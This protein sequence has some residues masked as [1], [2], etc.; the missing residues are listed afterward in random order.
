MTRL[1]GHFRLHRGGF[2]LDTAFDS[3]GPGVTALCGPSGAGKTS[4][5]R[6]L[7]GLETPEAGSLTVGGEVW[8]DAERGVS[9][10]PQRRSIGY[11]T[12]E[13]SLFAHLTVED[14]L[15]YGFKRLAES[16]RKASLDDVVDGL[17]LK[18]LLSRRVTN[19]SGG[20]RQ[21]VAIGR[22]LLRSPQVLLLDE[23]VSALDVA[24]RADVLR[25]LRQVLERFAVRSIYVSHDLRE[26]ARLAN[27]MLWMERGKV[28]AQGNARDVLTDVHL[29]FAE[30][31]EAES[32]LDGVIEGHDEQMGLTR[33]RCANTTLWLSQVDAPVGS[34]HRVQIAAR[35]VSLAL[36]APGAVSV[37]NVLEANVSDLVVAP[38][39][40]AQMIV[41][42]D[43]AGHPLLA[44]I[45]R[46]SALGL[47]LQ[48]GTPVWALVKSV[49]LAE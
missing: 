47:Q 41:R 36:S 12:Q 25:Y 26:A 15:L 28:V 20:E 23:P 11:V 40:P 49:A 5:L 44:R 29:P 7:A 34:S 1:N 33:I 8:F 30:L 14:N 19:L 46:K 6:C 22:A 27:E 10:P 42:L 37:L 43:V 48:P 24:G 21:R 31:D 38:R 45:T 32:L 4:L 13:P 3:A 17:G 9:V 35:D 18:A 39:Q 2:V 16:A